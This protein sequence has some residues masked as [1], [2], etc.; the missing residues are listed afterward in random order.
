M[1]NGLKLVKIDEEKS[2]GIAPIILQDILRSS[3]F[4]MAMLFLV[5]A[6]AVITS[7]IKHSHVESID[8]RRLLVYRYV[9]VNKI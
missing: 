4:N 2:N 1:E 7:S 8:N 5:L 3:W 9:E 6:N